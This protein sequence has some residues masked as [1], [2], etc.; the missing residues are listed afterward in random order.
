MYFKYDNGSYVQDPE[1]ALVGA[2]AIDPNGNNFQ[3]VIF[4]LNFTS[5]QYGQSIEYIYQVDLQAVG[6]ELFHAIRNQTMLISNSNYVDLATGLD[7]PAEDATTTDEET[8]AI[9]INDGYSGEFDYF[10]NCYFKGTL[11]PFKPMYEF[12]LDR[13]I[14]M[15]TRNN[16]DIPVDRYQV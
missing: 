16:P 7:A 8:G 11:V 10:V 9:T 2:A 5:L 4:M 15:E 13:A 12:M 14:V 1:G 3:V 6:L